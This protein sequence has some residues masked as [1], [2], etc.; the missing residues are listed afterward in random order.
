M[1]SKG[2]SWSA[3]S[4][5]SVARRVLREQP[6]DGG[7]AVALAHQ[8]IAGEEQR[9][10]EHHAAANALGVATAVKW[11]PSNSSASPPRISVIAGGAGGSGSSAPTMVPNGASGCG[12]RGSSLGRPHRRTRSRPG[13]GWRRR[14]DP[15]GRGRTHR[16]DVAGGEALETSARRGS[17]PP[18]RPCRRRRGR[19]RAASAR[20]RRRRC[21]LTPT[22][23]APA[24]T[25]GPSGALAGEQEAEQQ[26]GQEQDATSWTSARFRILDFHR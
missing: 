14:R 25:R 19:R 13:T 3:G 8:R 6:A 5:A 26:D 2:S 7:Q 12:R 23:P 21:W 22:T 1:V 4:A 15:G 17:P 24:S 18:T 9:P 16:T 10:V 20:S 11:I